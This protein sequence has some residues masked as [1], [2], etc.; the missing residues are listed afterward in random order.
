MLSEK[1]GRVIVISSVSGGGKTSLIRMLTRLHPQLRNATTA[2]SR[3]PRL[4]EED[5][6]HYHFLSPEEFKRRIEAGEFIEHAKVHGNYY[7]VPAGPLLESLARGESVILNIDVQGFRHVR[8]RMG[9]DVVSIF[10]MPP[11]AQE[12]EARLRKRGTDSEE[13][14]RRRL[15]EGRHEMTCASQFDYRVVNEVLEVAVGEVSAILQE[16]GVI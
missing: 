10:L 14:I 13:V 12:W 6:V 16:E 4:G 11:N 8:E 15:E 9:K 7:G 5:G 3:S 1:R 2:T